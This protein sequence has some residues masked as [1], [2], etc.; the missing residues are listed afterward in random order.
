MP[1]KTNRNVALSPHDKHHGRYVQ[2]DT[3]TLEPHTHQEIYLEGM[4]F[5]LILIKQVFVNEGGSI[6]VLYL[7]SS[8]TMLTYDDL[9]TIY[10]KRWNVESYH[11]SLKQNASL[12]WSP[13]QTVTTQTNHFFAA[14]CSYIKLNCSKFE[15]KPITLPCVRGCIYKHCASPMTP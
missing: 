3:L 12:E 2:V 15:P 6:G 14:L 13:T 9:T 8:D 5:P 7:V 10:R 11:K 1:I 4:Y